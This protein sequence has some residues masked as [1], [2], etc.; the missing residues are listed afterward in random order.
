MLEAQDV[1]YRNSGDLNDFNWYTDFD[2]GRNWRNNRMLRRVFNVF[3]REED[4]CSK[5]AVTTQ[6]IFYVLFADEAE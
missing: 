3:G 6:L 4:L 2:N 5:C 1:E